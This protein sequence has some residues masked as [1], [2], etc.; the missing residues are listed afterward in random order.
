MGSSQRCN[1]SIPPSF[2][3]KGVEARKAMAA[4]NSSSPN[5]T[6]ERETF[7]HMYKRRTHGEEY[8]RADLEHHGRV[9]NNFFLA[10]TPFHFL[11][12]SDWCCTT[13]R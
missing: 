10:V 12:F 3:K 13:R 1:K 11:Q 8:V 9:S 7:G 4:N 6:K 5:Q 2:S